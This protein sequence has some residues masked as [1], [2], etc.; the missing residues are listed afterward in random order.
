VAGWGGRSSRRIDFAEH[1]GPPQPA[2]RPISRP[3]A[4][5]PCSHAA[6]GTSPSPNGGMVKGATATAGAARCAAAVPMLNTAA[7]SE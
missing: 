2:P 1:S 7:L 3:A 4:R 5:T 6:A